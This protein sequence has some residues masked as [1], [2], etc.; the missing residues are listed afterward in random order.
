LSYD[1]DRG[2]EISL[3]VPFMLTKTESEMLRL[4]EE[5]L[6]VIA[7]QLKTDPK[8]EDVKQV[9]GSSWIIFKYPRLLKKFGFTLGGRHE[10]TKEAF[11]SMPRDAFI[12]KY[13]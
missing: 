7:S 9:S 3:H 8:F 12:A 6:H 5:G 10:K 2:D 1:L 4:F 11:A 13:G